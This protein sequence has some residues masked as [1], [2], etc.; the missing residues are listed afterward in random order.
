MLVY[1]KAPNFIFSLMN[2]L[3]AC[4]FLRFMPG[5]GN[6]RARKLWEFSGSPESIF[7][8]SPEDFQTLEDIGTVHIQLIKG[9]KKYSDR[10]YKAEE[11]LH[12]NNIKTLFLGDP[13]YPKTLTFCP[14]APLV[15]FYKGN[16][17]FGQ[18][19]LVSIVGTRSGD[20]H[21]EKICRELVAGL[22]EFDPIIVSGFARG[23]DIIAHDQALKSNLTTIACMAHGLDQIYPPEH[24]GISNKIQ[25][26]GAYF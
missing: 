15:L 19:K 10:V 23:I 22:R 14:D 7:E 12:K 21:G 13:A 16:L 9:W 6:I 18:R 20:L 26:G 8:R 24:K 17:N 11:N 25:E 3:Q 5:F 2:R 1:L 4:L